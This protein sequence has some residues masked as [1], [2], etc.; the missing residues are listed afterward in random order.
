MNPA[1]I[2]MSSRSA[3]TEAER[4]ARCRELTDQDR[5]I[6]KVYRSI[7]HGS[8]VID[9][10]ET[11]KRGGIHTNGLPKLAFSR[12]DAR[13]V[14]LSMETWGFQFRWDVGRWSRREQRFRFFWPGQQARSASA[15]LPYIPPYLRR[16]DMSIHF[17]L[18][19]ATWNSISRG[20]P[21]LLAPVSNNFYRIVG[22]W[23]I[24]PVEAAALS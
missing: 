16:K 10:I 15:Q 12:A 24:T 4:Y 21:Y 5:A 2:E 23:D 9:L 7:A 19:E 13:T 1:L 11:M 22:A 8:K 14:S 18:W 20:D 6:M 17:V 3:R